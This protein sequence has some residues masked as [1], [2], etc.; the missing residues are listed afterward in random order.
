MKR[1]Y[2]ILCSGKNNNNYKDG[3]TLTKHYCIDCDKEIC[4]QTASYGG[5]RCKL[6]SSRELYKIHR[7]FE[8]LDR[9]KYKR[10]TLN[11]CCMDCGDLVS[12]NSVY[13]GSGCCKKCSY[14]Y[15]RNYN[16]ENNPNW[17]PELTEFERIN[18]RNI[19]INEKWIKEILERDNYTCIICYSKGNMIAHHLEGYH[20]CDE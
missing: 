19:S 6:C 4:W 18:R 20:W 15:R 9:S 11:Y 8:G 17:N 2:E 7:P 14:K 3:R 1:K 12:Y 13:Y 16:R 10:K 5:K